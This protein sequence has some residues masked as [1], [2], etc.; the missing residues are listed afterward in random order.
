MDD[1]NQ[2]IENVDGEIIE[3]SNDIPNIPEESNTLEARK[4]ASVRFYVDDQVVY[5]FDLW[6][7]SNGYMPMTD[8][9]G[10]KLIQLKNIINNF[11]SIR[12]DNP[13]K[14]KDFFAIVGLIRFMFPKTMFPMK[15]E[16]K[17]ETAIVTLE[18]EISN[19][20]KMAKLKGFRVEINPESE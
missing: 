10:H 13:K 17:E 11:D 16:D 14:V 12:P 4:F 8:D 15:M 7:T 5:R 20:I 18:N 9:N 19:N 1:N 3:P 2:V 6:T